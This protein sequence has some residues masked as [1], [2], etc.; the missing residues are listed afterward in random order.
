MAFSLFMLG[1]GSGPA[2]TVES[3]NTTVASNN[4]LET[5]KPAAEK[6]TNDA[7]TLTPLLKA[8]CAAK[9]KND[10]PQMRKM[11]SSGTIRSFE[12]QMKDAN[13]KTL[14]EFLSDEKVDGKC[15]VKNERITGDSAVASIYTDTYPN[16][17]EMYFERENGEWKMTN[18]SPTFE[19]DK[20]ANS[21]AASTA[22]A[23]TS[24]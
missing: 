14:K 16:G 13:I 1:C 12:E 15:E 6:V 3:G 19:A 17:I 22:N 5:T 8:Y 7:P 18:K 11:Y 10:E 2:N 20:K 23:N 4:P 24:K 21:N 9:L